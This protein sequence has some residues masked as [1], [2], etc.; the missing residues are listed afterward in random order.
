MAVRGCAVRPRRANWPLTA[1]RRSMMCRPRSARAPRAEKRLGLRRRHPATPRSARNRC[2]LFTRYFVE[3]CT[4]IREDA[5]GAIAVIGTCNLALRI[6][7]KRDGLRHDVPQAD[8]HPHLSLR[9][10]RRCAENE[11]RGPPTERCRVG[12]PIARERWQASCHALSPVD[13][14]HLQ[15]LGQTVA[16]GGPGDSR[17]EH[18]SLRSF[19][20]CLGQGERHA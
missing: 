20:D 1:W 2:Q 16:S 9:P 8:R 11:G 13:L 5:E 17:A 10:D 15:R 12:A 6:E 4:T 19:D 3:I 18:S 7:G 14:T